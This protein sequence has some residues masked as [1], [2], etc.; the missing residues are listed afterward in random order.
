MTF[1]RFDH[2]ENA[3]LEITRELIVEFEQGRQPILYSLIGNCM[4][5]DDL[6]DE[7]D[8][9]NLSDFHFS[10]SNQHSCKF[11]HQIHR[12]FAKSIISEILTS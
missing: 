5:E 4:S 6:F 2:F 12:H 11:A 1:E 7:I 8:D 3:L 9:V 10:N